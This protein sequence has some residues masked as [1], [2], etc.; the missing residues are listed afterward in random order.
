MSKL[1]ERI[2]P[3]LAVWLERQHVFF[4]A[5]A[6]LSAEQHVNCSPK[7]GDSFRVF[8]PHL[9]AY[10]DYTGS[11][12]ETVA[13]LRENGRIVLMFCAFDGKPNIVRL[14]GKGEV[15]APGDPDF[16]DLIDRFASR[17][18]RAGPSKCRECLDL[19]WILGST[20]GLSRGS[21]SAREMERVQ[22]AGWPS[23]VSAGEERAQHRRARRVGV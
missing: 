12:A 14:H 2:D 4:V 8:G 10:Q 3:E 11:G 16:E 23:R 18:P 15:L 5:A 22:G 13:H 6:P 9:V 17:D 21:L 20:H 1:V 19:M 7:G